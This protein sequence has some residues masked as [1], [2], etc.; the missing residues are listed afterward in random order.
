MNVNDTAIL[1]NNM[2]TTA[3]KFN[4]KTKVK[5]KKRENKVIPYLFLLPAMFFFF[6]FSFFPFFKTIYT[7]FFITDAAGMLKAFV[8]VKNY[9]DTF[10]RTDFLEIVWNTFRFIPILVIPSI[11]VALTLATLAE[12]KIRGFSPVFETMFTMPMAVASATVAIIWGFIFDPLIGSLNY[13]LGK[14]ISW[15]TD[16][17]ISLYSIGIVTVWLGFGMNFI[18]LLTA[19]RGVPQD[20][21]ESAMIDGANWWHKF[22]K[23]TLPMI[24]PTLF[25]VIFFNVMASFQSFGQIKLLTAG[26]PGIST[27]TLIYDIYLEAFRNYRFGTACAESIILFVIMLGFALLQFKFEDRSVHYN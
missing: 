11:V 26:G 4:K 10:A 14:D 20:I 22:R 5:T 6:S 3:P 13:I 16:P 1:E 19:I 12:K 24:S 23:I 17:S 21:K 25:F 15:L 8:G 18:F 27:T 7:S 2:M 9:I